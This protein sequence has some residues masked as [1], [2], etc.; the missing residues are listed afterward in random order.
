MMIFRD[1]GVCIGVPNDA[2]AEMLCFYDIVVVY[3]SPPKVSQ[4][5]KYI[6]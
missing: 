5:F 4:S 2:W 1:N 6:M 3:I